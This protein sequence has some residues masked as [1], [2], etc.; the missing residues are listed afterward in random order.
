MPASLHAV[1]ELLDG[2]SSVGC[3]LITVL[4][5]C[6]CRYKTTLCTLGEKCNREICFFAHR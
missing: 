3:K 2:Y 4:C 1:V 6:A 5:C